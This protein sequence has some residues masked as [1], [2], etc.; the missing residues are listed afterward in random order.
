MY[1]TDTILELKEKR[2]TDEYLEKNGQPFPYDEVRVI[3]KSPIAHNRNTDYTGEDAQ[4]VIVQPATAG[5]FGSN[6]DEPFGKLRDL[7]NVKTLPEPVEVEEP[8]VR[9]IDANTS[10]AG[11]TPEEVFAREA[12]GKP[13]D[14]DAG[15]VGSPLPDPPKRSD[16]PLGD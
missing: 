5:A 1:A 8:R 6:L 15:P 9:I 4:G 7:Y 11:E 10:E 3:G 14:P 13:R 2:T 12:P 16:S